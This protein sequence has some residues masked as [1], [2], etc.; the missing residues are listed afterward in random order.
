MD[1]G[2][3][4]FWEGVRASPPERHGRRQRR[5][6]ARSGYAANGALSQ[7]VDCGIGPICS[8]SDGR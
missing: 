6:R 8:V 2:V 1:M 7:I 3:T 5:F 4:A